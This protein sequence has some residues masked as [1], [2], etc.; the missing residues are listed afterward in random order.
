RALLLC[1]V[2]YCTC[3]LGLTQIHSED[4]DILQKLGL[5]GQKPSPEGVIPFRAGIILNQRAHIE[6]QFHSVLPAAVWPN[7][8]LVLS[9]RSHRVNSAFL[10]TLLS[11]NKKLLLGLQLVPGSLVLHTGPSTSVTLPYESHDGQWHQLAL[12][13]N[14]KT[15]TL[16]ASCGEQS[17][18]ADFAWDSEEG[19]APEL[20]GSFLLGR[21]SQHQASGY[22]E[23]AI[24]QFDLVPS[25]QAAHNYCKYIKK[26]CREA[27]TYRPNLSPLLPILPKVTNISA[28][29][30][31]P[32]RGGPETAK[33]TTGLSLARNVAAA[34]SA[35]RYVAPTH[36]KKPNQIIIPLSQLITVTPATSQLGLVVPSSMTKT[37]TVTA[38]L[39]TPPPHTK[40]PTPSL[41]ASNHKSAKPTTPKPTPEKNLKKNITRTD[42]KKVTT[43][44]T[45][46]TKSP[47][48]KPDTVLQDQAEVPNKPQPT[49]AKKI[50]PEIKVS[51]SKVTL[52]RSKSNPVKVNPSKSTLPK[53]K[54]S[55]STSPK[56]TTAIPSKP[57]SKQ[58]T[59]PTKKP[60]TTKVPVAP[61]PTKPTYNTVTPPATDGFLSWEVPPTQF[62]MLAG[63]KGQKGDPGPPGLQGPPGKPGLPGKKGPRGAPGPHGNPGRPG[64]PGLKGKK[65]DPGSSPGLAPK[66]EKGD[67]GI[68]GPV[69]Q[70][71]QEGRKG[72]KGYPGPPGL[73]GEP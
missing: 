49:S 65:G 23:G 58:T 63:P 67:S 47:K 71:G 56:T 64:P 46:T 4:V 1:T 29:S 2:L 13:I 36:T 40:S 7:L 27:D 66:G 26:Q 14:G 69:G 17:V 62:S 5:K 19:L 61:R 39:R 68:T 20:K 12:G 15:V 55:K 24:C 43:P 10:F 54:P 32:K 9:I 21:S 8:A 60:K 72:Q 48:T 51:P 18:Q 44:A 53:A 31:T 52:P 50:L 11:S 6:A 33:K 25:A 16:Y 41:K 22:F 34:A 70:P 38:P 57:T 45:F 30:V 35:V 37:E 3:Y 73:P 28:T 42:K 59:K